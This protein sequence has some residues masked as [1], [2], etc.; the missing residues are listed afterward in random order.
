MDLFSPY[1][2]YKNYDFLGTSQPI[3]NEKFDLEA[4]SLEN[5]LQPMRVR[6]K[7]MDAQTAADLLGCSE[8]ETEF[9][10]RFLLI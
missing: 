2:L 5:T 6:V 10:E 4:A 7:H 3:G 8:D 9:H 1:Y